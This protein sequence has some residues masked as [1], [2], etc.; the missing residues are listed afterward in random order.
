MLEVCY[1][2]NVISIVRVNVV[3]GLNYVVEAGVNVV[4]QKFVVLFM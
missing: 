3:V 1:L 4:C 2:L